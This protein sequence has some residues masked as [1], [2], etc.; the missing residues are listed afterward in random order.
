MRNL[1]AFLFRYRGFLVF[2]LLEVASLY[3][4]IR[5]STYQRAAFL[6]PRSEF[7]RRSMIDDYGCDPARVIRVG[8][9]ANLA[10]LSVLTNL[11]SKRLDKVLQA[12]SGKGKIFCFDREEKGYVA[13]G[14]SAVLDST[15]SRAD[16]ETLLVGLDWGTNTSSVVMSSAISARVSPCSEG[17]RFSVSV[18]PPIERRSRS[19]LRHCIWRIGSKR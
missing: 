17:W 3:L 13:A 5:N 16:T 7:L 12:L 1:F 8:G 14:A 15:Q 2:A 6:F 9:G 19:E 4:L 18:R 10:Q 11:D